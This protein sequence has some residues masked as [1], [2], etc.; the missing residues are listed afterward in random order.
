MV[1]AKFVAMVEDHGGVFTNTM[2]AKVLL[3]CRSGAHSDAHRRAHSSANA[4]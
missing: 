3:A 4:G 2:G 1:R